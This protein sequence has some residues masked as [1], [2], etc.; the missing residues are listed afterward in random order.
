MTPPL[1]HAQSSSS[2]DSVSSDS[3]ERERHPL[4][5]GAVAA[6]GTSKGLFGNVRS[7]L[8]PFANVVQGIAHML[9]FRSKRVT[10]LGARGEPVDIEAEAVENHDEEGG[11]Q[12]RWADDDAD[13]NPR[14]ALCRVPS[15]LVLLGC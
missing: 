15:R 12:R 7:D 1:H 14:G 13:G 4:L 11:V 8:I 6:H 9:G 3:A 10:V 5:P 2:L